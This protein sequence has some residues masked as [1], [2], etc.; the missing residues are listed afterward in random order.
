MVGEAQVNS[1]GCFWAQ[2]RVAYSLQRS[3]TLSPRE[4]TTSSHEDMNGKIFFQEKAQNTSHTSPNR[5]ESSMYK[6][7]EGGEV[8]RCFCE[9]PQNKRIYAERVSTE[10]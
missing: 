9:C 2:K 5:P 1:C 6:G 7:P 10:S 8:L 3:S 4:C